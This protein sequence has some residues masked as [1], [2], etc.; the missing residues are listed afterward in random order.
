MP[1]FSFEGKSPSVHPTAFIA[2]TATLVGD[3]IVEEGASVWYNAVIRGDF[4]QVIIQAGANVQD[5]S[6]L[7]APPG[8]AGRRRD[9]V[10]RRGSRDR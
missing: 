6:L 10:S 2:P 1:L 4:E 7:H 9:R 8:G 3:V 5:G